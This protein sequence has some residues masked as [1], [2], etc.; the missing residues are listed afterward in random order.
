MM[1]TTRDLGFRYQRDWILRHVDLNITEGAFIALVGPNGGGKTTLLKILMGFLKPTEGSLNVCTKA[2]AYVPQTLRF[3]K[4][5]PISVLEVVLGGRLHALPW[6]GR[7][8][9][10][11]EELA[12]EALAEVGLTELE[13]APFGSLSGGQ[14]QRTLIARALV[15]HPE[16]LL[17]DEP[18]ASVDIQAE[19]DIYAL[20]SSLRKKKTILMVTHDLKAAIERVDRVLLVRGHVTALSPQEVCEHYAVGLYHPPLIQVKK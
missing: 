20:L 16:L 5:F 14:A 1:V 17:L 13:K 19:A 4:Q 18:T 15:S 3:D 9:R 7:F 6:H 11:D 2:I 10:H 12:R 8:C